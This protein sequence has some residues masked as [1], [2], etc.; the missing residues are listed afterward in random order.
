MTCINF[1]VLINWHL[2]LQGLK[3]DKEK[4]Q[5]NHVCTYFWSQS[6]CFQNWSCF[7]VEVPESVILSSLVRIWYFQRFNVF[8]CQRERSYTRFETADVS[9][10]SWIFKI[11]MI[12]PTIGSWDFNF[13]KSQIHC[14]NL[15]ANFIWSK[16]HIRWAWPLLL[17]VW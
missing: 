1:A 6:K 3:N 10:P 7:Y 5:R 11:W 12:H 2:R 8:T 15:S 14:Q 9:N 16:R 4:R 13:S 17:R